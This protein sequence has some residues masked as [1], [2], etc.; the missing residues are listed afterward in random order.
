MSFEIPGT[1][2][3]WMRFGLSPPLPSSLPIPAAKD[4]E[5]M[6]I[7]IDDD[8]A[9]PLQQAGPI[10]VMGGHPY[11]RPRPPSKK[12]K[13]A[14]GATWKTESRVHIWDLGLLAEGI[15][16]QGAV[17]TITPKGISIRTEKKGGSSSTNNKL[18]N[19]PTGIPSRLSVGTSARASSILSSAV[20][21]AQTSHSSAV[22]SST[23]G[24]AGGNEAGDEATDNKAPTWGPYTQQKAHKIIELG[25]VMKIPNFTPRTVA[26]SPDGKI[27][28][29][30]GNEPAGQMW[31][32]GMD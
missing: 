7:D 1:E 13:A 16:G 27:C 9:T 28:I 14:G 17:Q 8:N 10:L 3:F 12:T 29:V 22:V 6:D 18:L 15:L 25:T 24:G 31:I 30:V 32:M 20:S 11:R 19:P 26:W 2:G 23:S 4:S 5:A 21:H